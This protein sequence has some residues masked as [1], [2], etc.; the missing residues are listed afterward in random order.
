MR[1][2]SAGAI[3]VF[4]HVW[5]VLKSLPEIGTPRSFA[6]CISAGASTARLG[7]PFANGTP[8]MIE[9]HAYNIA[10]EIASSLRSIAFS[11]CSSVACCDPA[12]MYVS[13][14]AHQTITS[15]SSLC[16][17]LKSRTSCR[18]CSARSRF[19]LPFFTFVPL[20]RVT[21]RFSN[22]AGI[23]V[24]ALRKSAIGAM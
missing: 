22:T 8:S 10:G 3:T 21:Y 11:N 1:A 5:P 18:S 2:L 16:F 6:S 4:S 14:D 23:G 15:R 7:A 9:A 17:A 24:I 19:V 13:V 12:L 20:M